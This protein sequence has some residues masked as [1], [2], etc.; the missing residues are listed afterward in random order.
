[1]AVPRRVLNFLKKSKIKFE[2]IRHKKV[3]TAFDKS[4]TLK[5]PQKI[6]G[7]TLVLKVDKKLVLVL[8]PADKKLDFRKLKKLGKRVKLASERLIKNKLKGIKVGAVPP[9]GILWKVPTIVDTSF[10]KQKEII[11]NSGDWFH[12]I[13]ISPKNLQKIIP[14]LVWQKISLKK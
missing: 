12:S 13:K 5:V 1:M 9:F 6:V 7:K 8:I 14:D 3:F 4:Q 11:L 2:I 10:K